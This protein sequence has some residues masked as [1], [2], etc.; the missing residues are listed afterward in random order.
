MGSN[1]SNV[2]TNSDYITSAQVDSVGAQLQTVINGLEVLISGIGGS[3]SSDPYEDALKAVASGLDAAVN[4][5]NK[6]NLTEWSDVQ[7]ILNTSSKIND[8]SVF[9]Q[10]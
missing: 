6:L 10:P 3:N 7:T 4:A 2:L 8:A 9:Y 1:G 5:G